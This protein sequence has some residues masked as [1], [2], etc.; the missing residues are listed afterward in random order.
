MSL[1]NLVQAVVVFN[2]L[3]K[4]GTMADVAFYG[5]VYRV[6]TFLL[7]PIFGLM[8]ALQPVVGI[9]YGAK[10]YG[11]VIRSYKIFTFASMLLTLP[12]W[13]I[14]MVSPEAILGLMLPNQVFIG[15]Q[16]MYFR[17]YMLVLPVLSTIFT[18][19][20]FFPSIDKGRPAAVIGIIK[21]LVFFIPVMLILPRIIGVSG[22]YYGTLGIDVIIVLL[23]VV[24]VKK[25]F[26]ILRKRQDI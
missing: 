10:Q 5:A 16:V 14:S 26:N 7:T 4:Y 25:E 9:N 11:R 22:I 8:R 24:M 21:Q 13:I 18:A 3:S 19:M 2:A 23:T 15:T 20:T 12:F 6:F 17:I 1:M